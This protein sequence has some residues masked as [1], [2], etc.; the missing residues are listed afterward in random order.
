M[1]HLFA[2]QFLKYNFIL[3]FLLSSSCFVQVVKRLWNHIREN[4]LQDPKNKRNIICDES[5]YALFCVDSIDMF[6]MNKALSKHIWP[7]NDE[8]GISF[9]LFSLLDKIMAQLSKRIWLCC[10]CLA[11]M[12][13]HFLAFW[14]SWW[15]LCMLIEKCVSI[16]TFFRNLASGITFNLVLDNIF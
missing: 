14:I 1:F 15:F 12:A 11:I 7:L 5:L 6:Q 10:L 16:P 8:A 3:I 13:Y 9:K 2:V 4:N